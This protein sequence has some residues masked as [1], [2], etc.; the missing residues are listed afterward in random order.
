[1]YI[2]GSR[3]RRYS[4]IKAKE[5][6]LPWTEW[7][8]Q[9]DDS[10]D[11]PRNH[12]VAVDPVVILSSPWFVQTNK[13]FIYLFVFI[14]SNKFLWSWKSCSSQL[15]LIAPIKYRILMF[16]KS[17]IHNLDYIY[18]GSTMRLSHQ[19]LIFGATTTRCSEIIHDTMMQGFI[20]QV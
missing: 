18:V 9:T 2:W 17:D 8:N 20:D 19:C 14:K 5:H 16:K 13:L 10:G 3:Y 6:R 15:R 4:R 12:E 11:N 7:S 1:M